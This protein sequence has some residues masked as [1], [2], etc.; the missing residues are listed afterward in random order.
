V[1]EV[2]DL[3]ERPEIKLPD[4]LDC[5]V[6]EANAPLVVLSLLK[7]FENSQAQNAT[8]QTNMIDQHLHGNINLPNHK[9]H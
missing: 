6:I 5:A 9:E 7:N 8:D 4:R 3:P 1:K 2:T